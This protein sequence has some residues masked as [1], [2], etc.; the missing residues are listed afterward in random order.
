MAAT[1]PMIEILMDKD[2][3]EVMSTLIAK[4][5]SISYE[6]GRTSVFRTSWGNNLFGECARRMSPAGA[7]PFDINEWY[8]TRAHSRRT[9]RDIDPSL[10]RQNIDT[11]WL[12]ALLE[13]EL[14]FAA[15]ARGGFLRVLHNILEMED[16]A[17]SKLAKI[18]KTERQY[19]FEGLPTRCGSAA[20]ASARMLMPAVHPEP[21]KGSVEDL[22]RRN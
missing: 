3:I 7:L 21:A 14:K 15:S 17:A 19:N 22:L 4:M 10:Y 11:D 5:E 1:D 6:E 13:L 9:R 2:V 16:S 8:R 20:S 18:C 12:S